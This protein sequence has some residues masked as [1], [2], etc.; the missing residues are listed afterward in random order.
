MSNEVIKS[1]EVITAEPD[2]NQNYYQKKNNPKSEFAYFDIMYQINQVLIQIV[3]VNFG[4]ENQ[5]NKV[6]LVGDLMTMSKYDRATLLWEAEK[7]GIKIVNTPYMV[8]DFYKNWMLETFKC[9]SNDIIS[10]NSIYPNTDYEFNL[11]K[12]HI[13]EAMNGCEIL[14]QI[15]QMCKQI[16]QCDENKLLFFIDLI[17]KQ[18][19][20]LKNWKASCS[21]KYYQNLITMT[22]KNLSNNSNNKNV[23]SPIRFLS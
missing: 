22:K 16:F 10:A 23:H 14:I 6:M 5:E 19:N 18:R 13:T 9:I 17:I 11:K 20:R 4:F 8:L 15:V 21:S 7:Y 2:K 3:T 12:K 1:N